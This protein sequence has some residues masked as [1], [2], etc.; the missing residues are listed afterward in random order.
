MQTF[1]NQYKTVFF[2]SWILFYIVFPAWILPISVSARAFVFFGII[3]FFVM[4]LNAMNRWFKVLA[5]D[6]PLIVNPGHWLFNVKNNIWLSLICF[7]AAILHIYQIV[8]L[9]NLMFG[10]EALH[11]QG[12][13]W[14]YKYIDSNRHYYFQCALWFLLILFIWKRQTVTAV[15]AELYFK[16]RTNKLCRNFSI[17]FIICVVSG[18]FYLLKDLP[19]HPGFVRY[20][21]VSRLLYLASYLLFGINNTGPRILQLI[22]YLLTAI[23]LYRTVLLFN[24]KETALMGA[25][26]YLFLPIPY[27]YAHTAEL[28]SG[29]VFFITAFSYYF[30]RY[31]Q[32]RDN[33]DLFLASGL[34]SLGSLFHNLIFLTFFICI[35]YLII[36]K[37]RSKGR[38]FVSAISFKV[39]LISLVPVIP[40]M[41]IGR[42]FTWRNYDIVWP[43][44]LSLDRHA[45]FLS[46]M[47]TNVSWIIFILFLISAIFIVRDKKNEILLFFGFLFVSFYLF[48]V[49]DSVPQSARL[50]MTFYPTIAIYISQFYSGVINKIR[51]KQSAKT[52]YFILIFYLIA[53]SSISPL[54]E[55]FYLEEKSKVEQYPSEAAMKWIDDNV[56]EGEKVLTLRILP[57]EFYMAK[58]GVSRDK[59]I[60]LMYDIDD[61]STPENLI[62][63]CNINKISYIMFPFSTKPPKV[64]IKQVIVHKTLMYL[65][66]NKGNEF[67]EVARFNL[68]NNYI[69]IYK[70]KLN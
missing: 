11:L 68:G 35:A 51:L 44:L 8:T 67:L 21:P 4:S 15:L 40:W 25:C 3:I 23:Y 30:L 65:K 20:P 13:L 49:A 29:T 70:L 27:F 32:G 50:S 12:G 17:I 62:S 43:H 41:I 22:F 34:I 69:Y 56:K 57:A 14:I 33:R 18:Y 38:D 19:H 36:F 5:V 46:L 9:P 47:H 52:I 61:V 48:L 54:N 59:T 16:C 42:L 6:K 45:A 26:I 1:I 10:D 37:M 64:I 63:F 28:G 24:N 39:I 58:F 60:N 2:L 7:I 31:L 53:I 55:K 66:E